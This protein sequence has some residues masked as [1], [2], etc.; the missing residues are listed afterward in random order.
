MNFRRL[1][2]AAL[3]L[4]LS[5]AA[6]GGSG[7]WRDSPYDL[8]AGATLD[9]VAADVS[10]LSGLNFS[11]DPELQA[12]LDAEPVD[13]PVLL[14]LNVA[15]VLTLLQDM[16]P[17]QAVFL[18]EE[19]ADGNYV[20]RPAY[21]EAENLPAGATRIVDFDEFAELG[22]RAL[23]SDPSL[24]DICGGDEDILGQLGSGGVF[25]ISVS[26][27]SD[28]GGH[29]PFIGEFP[30]ILEVNIAGNA[31]GMFGDPPWVTVEGTIEADGGFTCSGS[32]MVAGFPDVQVDFVG[33]AA[34]GALNGTLT[35]GADGALPGGTPVIY[36]VSP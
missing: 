35:F 28:P 5:L 2:S 22:F 36:S 33:Q 34:P 1:K 18:Y 14:G 26:V 15:Q 25:E 21:T 24:P 11:I 7:D 6:C 8:A 29:A 12:R 3:V 27:V 19:Q 23:I 31:I 9:Q 20:L 17:P 4:L 13:L 16:M 30:P 10:K 32:G